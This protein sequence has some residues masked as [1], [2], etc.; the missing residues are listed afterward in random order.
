M[1]VLLLYVVSVSCA[2]VA[3]LGHEHGRVIVLAAAYVVEDLSELLVV[4]AATMIVHRACA[5]SCILVSLLTLTAHHVVLMAG[6]VI[7]LLFAAR[8]RFM[9]IFRHICLIYKLIN[10]QMLNRI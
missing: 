8:L 3:L 9:L 6:S 7:T 2:L 4:V 1:V 5:T 10:I